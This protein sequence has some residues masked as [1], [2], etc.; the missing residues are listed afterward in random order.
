MG[1]ALGQTPH[2]SMVVPE[3]LVLGPDPGSRHPVLSMVGLDPTTQ[4]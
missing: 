2:L 1:E 4:T 3:L